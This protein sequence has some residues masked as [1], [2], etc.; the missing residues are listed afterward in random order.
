M[1]FP[2][3]SKTSSRGRMQ[4]EMEASERQAGQY[5]Q[6]LAFMQNWWPARCSSKCLVWTHLSFTVIQPWVPELIPILKMDELEFKEVQWSPQEYTD[7][8][9][10]LEVGSKI[11]ADLTSEPCFL[12]LRLFPWCL[13]GFLP[14]FSE[15]I[16][17]YFHIQCCSDWTNQSKNKIQWK[18]RKDTPSQ[19]SEATVRLQKHRTG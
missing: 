12:F 1:L 2:K 14:A 15:G 9:G 3:T 18:G 5:K 7:R 8:E 4:R 11:L 10:W 19:L 13:P 17:S 16:Q 6:R